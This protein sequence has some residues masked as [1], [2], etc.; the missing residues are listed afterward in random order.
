MCL[1]RLKPDVVLHQIDPSDTL[2]CMNFLFS[3]QVFSIIGHS[4][5]IRLNHILQTFSR[6]FQIFKCGISHGCTNLVIHAANPSNFINSRYKHSEQRKM[7]GKDSGCLKVAAAF[8]FKRTIEC[9]ALSITSRWIATC[10]DADIEMP[11]FD[12]PSR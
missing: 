8:I 5:S 2:H 3:S 4:L 11:N 10:V 6:L 9:M 7:T 1:S 12:Y